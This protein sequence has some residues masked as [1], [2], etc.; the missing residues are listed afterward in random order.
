M[1]ETEV[2]T[3]SIKCPLRCRGDQNSYDSPFKN[4]FQTEWRE[5]RTFS[6]RTRS[7]NVPKKMN[8]GL[9]GG[10]WLSCLDLFRLAPP[11]AGRPPCP[12]RWIGPAGHHVDHEWCAGFAHFLCIM[13]VNVC[14]VH[15]QISDS[16]WKIDLRSE[17]HHSPLLPPYNEKLHDKKIK[18]CLQRVITLMLSKLLIWRGGLLACFSFFSFFLKMN[19]PL[20]CL[21][22]FWCIPVMTL[23]QIYFY[24]SPGLMARHKH[25]SHA[26]KLVVKF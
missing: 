5:R 21:V 15:C 14:S 1:S 10:L 23:I 12:P 19:Q 2:S 7:E 24:L 17:A 20:V 16:Y 4:F 9:G 11:T 3:G 25:G 13:P 18:M 8:F 6:I 26:N 22:C